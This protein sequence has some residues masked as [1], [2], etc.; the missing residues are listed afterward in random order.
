VAD[1]E[2]SGVRVITGIHGQ[3][4]QVHTIVGQGLFEFG[5][6]D[7]RGTGVR[8][9][10]CLG[11]AYGGGHLYIAD[12]YNNRIKICE[13]RARSVKA[14]FGIHKPGD[15]D[16]PPEFYEP[17][18]LSATE[19]RLFVAD[20][21]NHKIR[22]VDLKT[23]KVKT[24]ALEGLTPPQLAPRP[25]SFPNAK[26][27]D[28]ATAKAA[29]GQSIVLDVS[30]PLPKGFKLNEE[31]PLTYLVE[32]PEKGGVLG[33]EVLPEGQKV[34]PPATKFTV[35]VQLAKA[36]AAGEKLDLRLSLQTFVCNEKSTLCLIK[37]YIWNVPVA[38]SDEAA[39][40]HI[41]LSTETK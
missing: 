22:V 35:T 40:A 28:V 37:S 41:S 29:P 10:H 32:T 34:K 25:P 21:N 16:D 20:T 18:G 26:V 19:D 27:I 11:L 33:P 24:L 2:V 23:Q 13:P 38:F 39:G 7:G 5:D 31:V 4:P 8:L 14:F 30:V 9:Q 6:R 15:T 17:G 36:A 12:S 3:G 1:S